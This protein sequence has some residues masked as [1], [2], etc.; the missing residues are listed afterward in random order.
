MEQS[1]RKLFDLLQEVEDE[2]ILLEAHANTLEAE[3]DCLLK[4]I[5]WYDLA[6]MRDDDVNKLLANAK[7]GIFRMP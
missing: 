7:K 6:D 3:R 5:H 4:L 1:W 2:A